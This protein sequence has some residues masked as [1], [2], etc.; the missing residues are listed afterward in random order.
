MKTL[1]GTLEM[2][3]TVIVIALI[4]LC[5]VAFLYSVITVLAGILIV[6]SAYR[7][8]PLWLKIAMPFYLLFGFSFFLY[9]KDSDR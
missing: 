4:M 8:Y 3:V 5:F 6:E 7:T 2:M 9:L 1:L